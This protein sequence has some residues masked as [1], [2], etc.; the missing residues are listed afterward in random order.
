MRATTNLTSL[1]RGAGGSPPP[2]SAALGGLCWRSRD[3]GSGRSHGP[4]LRGWSPRWQVCPC[5]SAQRGAARPGRPNDQ[6]RAEETINRP[7][8][9]HSTAGWTNLQARPDQAHDQRTTLQYHRLQAEKHC[10]VK[11][12][13][14][15]QM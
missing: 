13:E 1:R 15:S 6:R 14:K 5:R 2:H 9:A 3:P 4:T 10:L 7:P 12:S 11:P 8:N